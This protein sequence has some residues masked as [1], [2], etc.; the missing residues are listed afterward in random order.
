MDY[1]SWS[2]LDQ[3]K[4]KTH[5]YRK[6]TIKPPGG[7]FISSSF[8][9]WLNKDAGLISFRKDNGISVLHKELE[10]KVEKL[11][12]MKVAGK[13]P[14]INPYEVVKFWAINTVYHSLVE[15]NQWRGGG[16]GLFDEKVGGAY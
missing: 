13:P 10:Y 1:L 8:E 4:F 7:L 15:N 12:Y 9:D 6:S 3:A 14:R 5:N 2:S 16:R 11:R